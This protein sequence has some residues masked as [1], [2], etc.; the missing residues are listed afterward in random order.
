[1]KTKIFI[2]IFTIIAKHS[3]AQFKK[4]HKKNN[5]QLRSFFGISLPL[6]A[7][8]K[9]DCYAAKNIKYSYYDN[10]GVYQP[11][12]TIPSY[13]PEALLST[14][15]MITIP[16]FFYTNYF[17]FKRIR[18]LPRVD[19]EVTLKNNYIYAQKSGIGPGSAGPGGRL[20]NFFGLTSK[21][22]LKTSLI[23]N[24]EIN[25][26]ISFERFFKI[27]PSVRYYYNRLTSDSLLYNGKSYL[28]PLSMTFKEQ[29]WAPGIA[30]AIGSYGSVK[31]PYKYIG[32]EYAF[33]HAKALIS[34]EIYTHDFKFI[35]GNS[36]NDF[37]S[38]KFLNFGVNLFTYQTSTH[39][40]SYQNGVQAYIEIQWSIFEKWRK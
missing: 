25:A 18:K 10:N 4:E 40:I 9:M 17:H 11:D 20:F 35:L 30:V 15:V 12:I 13:K 3:F 29:F 32:L 8:N 5:R 38:P 6:G 36:D 33:H 1:M 2:I 31:N 37:P 27:G 19:A 39:H 21:N 7:L 23:R 22:V 26:M 34:S 14:P 28:P 24:T 16:T